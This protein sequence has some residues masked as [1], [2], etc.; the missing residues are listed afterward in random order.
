MGVVG[1]HTAPTL[2][3]WALCRAQAPSLT[4][5]QAMTRLLASL[6]WSRVSRAPCTAQAVT[7]RSPRRLQM[8]TNPT[9]GWG[10]HGVLTH[11]ALS[12][13]HSPGMGCC[14]SPSLTHTSW[15]LTSLGHSLWGTYRVGA[16]WTTVR[17]WRGS[18]LGASPF[19]RLPPNRPHP[20]VSTIPSPRPAAP[21]KITGG[22]VQST[23]PGPSRQPLPRAGILPARGAQEPGDTL[24]RAAEAGP[25]SLRAK[26][27]LSHRQLEEV[28]WD[29]PHIP[30]G[31]SPAG[32]WL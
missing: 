24:Q 32:S 19:H 6:Q 22:M 5:P 21:D 15:P 14:G 11:R 10:L 13:E 2:R 18:L 7:Y 3:P 8:A 26:R 28:R 16:W 4:T 30:K 9:P 29:P 12:G 17:G 25:M 1:A 31:H 23:Q 27:C 20:T